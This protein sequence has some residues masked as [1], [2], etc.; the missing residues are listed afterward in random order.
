M[1]VDF[2]GRQWELDTERVRYQHAMVIQSYT[3]MSIGEWEDSIEVKEKVDA[4]GEPTGELE[5]PPPAWLKSVGSLY[6]LMLAQNEVKTPISE[7]D[8]DFGAFIVAL[9]EG[10]VAEME[11]RKADK[12]AEPDPTS[13]PRSPKGGP[14]SRAPSTRR[15]TTRTPRARAVVAGT[16]IKSGEPGT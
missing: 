2:E 7:M 5:N 13:P 15:A 9:M 8:F 3:G 12:A 10:M 1:I 14:P 11:R 6:W 16:V 4:D